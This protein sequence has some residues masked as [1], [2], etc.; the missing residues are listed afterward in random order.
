[1]PGRPLSRQWRRHWIVHPVQG[2]LILALFKAIGLL[3]I[4]WASGLGGFLGRTVG[5][6]VPRPNRRAAANLA[7]AFP[8]KSAAERQRILR[9][10][11]EHLGRVAAEYPVLERIRDAGRVEI[12]GAHH[13]ADHYGKRPMVL[14]SGHIGHWEL[15]P[16]VGA[17]YGMTVT[18]VYRPPNNRFVDRLTRRLR[19]ACGLALLPRGRDSVRSALG[20]LAQGGNL[21]MLVDQKRSYGIPVPLFGHPAPTGP[22]LAQMALR[23]DC[24]VMPVRVERLHGARFRV[25]C[26]PPVELSR[27]GDHD[28]DVLAIM[29][30]VNRII[31]GWVRERPEQ[32]LWP[33]RRWDN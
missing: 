24:L 10:M 28:A 9:D 27:T 19:E 14:F 12:A 23:F 26:L 33:H 6:L 5:P 32:W 31:E 25:T 18:A 30:A 15:A 13:I 17:K 1:M 20:V 22:A 4:D 3:P 8:E 29:T 21:A 2:A 11:W 7:L 16:A